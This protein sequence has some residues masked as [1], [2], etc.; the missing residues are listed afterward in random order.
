MKEFQK[1]EL[2]LFKFIWNI[3]NKRSYLSG[4][5][6]RSIEGT[7]LWFNLFAHILAKG[8]NQY[9]HF[10]LYIGNIKLLTPGEHALLDHGAESDRIKYSKK[11]KT[12]NWDN[13]YKLRDELRDLY[14]EKF[15]Y[16][17]QGIIGYR[18]SQEEVAA[19]I[20][21]M[22][23]A[24]LAEYSVANSTAE[25]LRLLNKRKKPRSGK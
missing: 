16:T 25:Y 5:H 13:I 23:S 21:E 9:P 7:D 15:P 19:T 8:Q 6:L 24:W 2:S 12:A 18:Y 22:N 3:S 1:S 14:K 20:K 4:L 17:Y 11:V 10:K